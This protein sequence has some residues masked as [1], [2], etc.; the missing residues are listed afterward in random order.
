MYIYISMVML[1]TLKGCEPI[2]TTLL[3]RRGS[4]KWALDVPSPEC[5]LAAERSIETV[6][7]LPSTSDVQLSNS[8]NIGWERVLWRIKDEVPGLC[9][10]W[11]ALCRKVAPMCTF[12][13]DWSVLVKLSIQLSLFVTSNRKPT[14]LLTVTWVVEWMSTNSHFKA[15]KGS[16]SWSSTVRVHRFSHLWV[17]VYIY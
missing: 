10:Q 1:F 5:I 3:G 7:S 15:S 8:R 16:D 4:V 12:S 6:V 13:T 11:Q 9:S 2:S 14:Y 17:H